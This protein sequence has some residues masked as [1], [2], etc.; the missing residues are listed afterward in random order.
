[1]LDK[2]FA[3]F[4]INLYIGI[5]TIYFNTRLLFFIN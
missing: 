2:R 1:M 3:K 5:M 4:N